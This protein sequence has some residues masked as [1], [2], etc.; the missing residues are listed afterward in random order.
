GAGKEGAGDG[1]D[2]AGSVGETGKDRAE[3]KSGTADRAAAREGRP[4]GRPGQGQHR[5]LRS[6]LHDWLNRETKVDYEH[7]KKR[8]GL[9]VLLAIGFIL[10]AL[11][12]IIPFAR[13]SSRDPIWYRAL[14]LFGTE[15]A[16]M[17]GAYRALVDFGTEK[18]GKRAAEG[19]H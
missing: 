14:Q 3:A 13:F 15:A 4:G 19:D 17:Y 16:V 1:R 7:W 8:N 12:L 18:G 6:R 10:V 9:S 5:D 11:A 2:S